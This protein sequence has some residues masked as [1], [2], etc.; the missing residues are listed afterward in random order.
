MADFRE[1]IVQYGHVLSAYCDQ[2]ST[3]ETLTTLLSDMEA[4]AISV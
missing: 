1:T 3:P 4:T 2:Q